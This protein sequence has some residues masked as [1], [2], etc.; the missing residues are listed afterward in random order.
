M[1]TAQQEFQKIHDIGNTKRVAQHRTVK[2]NGQYVTQITL[3]EGN[4]ELPGWITVPD[5]SA[6][7]SQGATNKAIAA[8]MDAPVSNET[9]QAIGAKDGQLY[10]E[11][12][13]PYRSNPVEST[14][15]LRG[16]VHGMPTA[17]QE[18]QDA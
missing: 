4:N 17:E 11:D 18:A 12:S 1:T 14:G 2:I 3:A 16:V 6:V 10:Y 5:A 8:Y 13:N 7:T 9:R 15:E